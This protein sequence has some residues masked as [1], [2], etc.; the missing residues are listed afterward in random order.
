MEAGPF[1]VQ[2]FVYLYVSADAGYVRLLR[3]ASGTISVFSSL[4]DGHRHLYCGICGGFL[5]FV[6]PLPGIGEESAGS[7]AADCGY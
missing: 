4:C 6:Q 1:S 2:A 5:F 3:T 7:Q